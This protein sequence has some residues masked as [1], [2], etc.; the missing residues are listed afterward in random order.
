MLQ[1]AQT[2]STKKQ[3]GDNLF[4]ASFFPE[5]TD[6]LIGLYILKK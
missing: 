3:L 5:S 1:S 2:T 6:D 4:S